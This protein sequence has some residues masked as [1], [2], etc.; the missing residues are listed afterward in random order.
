MSK[1]MKNFARIYTI[2]KWQNQAMTSQCYSSIFHH[3][4]L[5]NFNN[6]IQ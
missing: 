2:E 6:F 1:A 3:Y 4:V 5:L